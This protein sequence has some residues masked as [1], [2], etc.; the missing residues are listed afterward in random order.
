MD[1]SNNRRFGRYEILDEIGRGAMGVVYRARDPKINRTV[2]VK[3]ISPANQSPDAAS[4][5][6]ER[7]LREAEAAGRL[8]H[9]GIVTIFDVGE[10]PDTHELYLV[11]ECVKGKS[12]DKLL[13]E[14]GRFAPDEAVRLAVELAEA[15]D[16][17]HGQNI[18]HRD[19]KP[20]NILVT[21][22]GHAKIGDFG[23][24][25]LSVEGGTHRREV[26]GT[27]EFMSP[28]QLHGEPVDGRSDLF[29]LGVILY[30][31]LTG[32]RPFQGNS[33]LTISLR[34]VTHEPVPA[35]ALE[36]DLPAGLDYVLSRALEKN[37]VQR[38]QRGME[39]SLDL[40]NVLIGREPW[41]ITRQH[42]TKPDTRAPWDRPGVRERVIGGSETHP[43][44]RGFSEGYQT[45]VRESR[46][47]WADFP[48]IRPLPFLLL[49]IVL[50]GVARKIPSEASDRPASSSQTQLA[51]PGDRTI[52]ST[53]SSSVPAPTLAGTTL[54]PASQ[55]R[56]A[57]K[58]ASSTRS[59]TVDI[60]IDNQLPQANVTIWVDDQAVF[61]RKLPGAPKKKLGIFGG[62]PKESE[63]VKIAAGQHQLR[64]RVQSRDPFYDQSHA[65]AGNFPMGAERTLRVSFNKHD[66]MHAS[67]K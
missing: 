54:S 24:A 11:M 61:R 25:Q 42:P 64:V 19:L 58:L 16:C 4:E 7:F 10:Q 26:W 9:S 18:V 43:S 39:M 38:Y 13:E 2:A 41:T 31:L 8:S 53:P 63:K 12:L 50:L 45:V 17:A 32:H 66:E 37:P 33:P 28:E 1:T 22:E 20:A 5:F 56:P 59:A 27:P 44:R 62:S 47:M 48:L 46:R 67:L 3:T 52:P 34:V 14:K 35:I 36:P 6:R 30:T 40:Q 15:L 21:E 57:S 49:A 65:L 55:V 23:I 51:A 60:Q 29:S